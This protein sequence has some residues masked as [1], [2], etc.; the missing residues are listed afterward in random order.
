MDGEGNAWIAN[1]DYVYSKV[2]ELSNSGALLSGSSG[3]TGGGIQ[4]PLYGVA[5]DGAGKVWVVG[6]SLIELSSTGAILSGATGYQ[7]SYYYE[8]SSMAIDGSGDVWVANGSTGVQ[9]PDSVLEW[10]GV[11]TPVVTP[12]AAGLPATPTLDGSSNLGT[13]P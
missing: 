9:Q 3:Y 13:R 2:Y 4:S 12:I 11:S 5:I 6:A 8:P 1:G 7:N 10:I